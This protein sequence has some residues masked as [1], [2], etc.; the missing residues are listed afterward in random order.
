MH[1]DYYDDSDDEAATPSGRSTATELI[2]ETR[3]RSHL[4]V[5]VKAFDSFRNRDVIG[6]GANE[7]DGV[8]AF[9]KAAFSKAAFSK[10]AFSK[11]AFSKATHGSTSE[12]PG[13]PLNINDQDP[14]QIERQIRAE[15]RAKRL[16]QKKELEERHNESAQDVSDKPERA[17]EQAAEQGPSI[18]EDVS[19][20]RPDTVRMLAQNALAE[21][22]KLAGRPPIAHPEAPTGT[23]AE[24]DTPSPRYIFLWK[25]ESIGSVNTFKGD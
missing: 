1:D 14:L 13:K 22:G 18:P 23:L 6:L 2:L 19:D 9:S 7:G 17:A 10:A 25:N 11:A 24:G 12:M 4:F 20:N 15:R 8:A 3:C 16:Q 21:T 5:E